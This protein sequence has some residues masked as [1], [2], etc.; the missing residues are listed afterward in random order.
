[1]NDIQHQADILALTFVLNQQLSRYADAAMAPLG[2][3]TRQWLLLALIEKAFP[4]Q[5]PTLSEAA[6]VHGSSRQNIKQLALQLESRGFLQLLADPDDQ[7]ALRL[8]L[9]DKIAIFNQP[10][11]IA[12]QQALLAEIFADFSSADLATL[13]D[14]LHRLLVNT[15]PTS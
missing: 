11:E 13:L 4:G 6:R 12:R 2:L 15:T 1:M 8:Q 7:R 9:T 10:V 5:Q 14:L 3:T